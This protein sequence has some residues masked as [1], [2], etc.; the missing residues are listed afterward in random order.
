LTA[1]GYVLPFLGNKLHTGKIVSQLTTKDISNIL[2]NKTN[3]DISALMASLG[4][5]IGQDWF[6]IG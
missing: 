1:L 4:L 6:V 2:M 3:S 5:K